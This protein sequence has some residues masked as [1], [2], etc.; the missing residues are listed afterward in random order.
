MFL[1]IDFLKYF[2]CF[3][4]NHWCWS[5]LLIKLKSWSLAAVLKRASI[6]G[7]FL[8][9]LRNFMK[10]FYR[11]PPMAAFNRW[12]LS[13]SLSSLHFEHEVVFISFLMFWIFLIDKFICETL[14]QVFILETGIIYLFGCLLLLSCF[15]FSL[16]C[17]IY[18]FNWFLDSWFPFVSLPPFYLSIL[19][20]Q[21]LSWSGHYFALLLLASLYTAL[22][23]LGCFFSDLSIFHLFHN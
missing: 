13:I 6:A 4:E 18:N 9:N 11:T 20:P 22:W 12:W 23:N 17:I 5:F 15:L 21:L 16:I 1:K 19:T 7:F 8:W 10:A 2:T 14:I 3:I